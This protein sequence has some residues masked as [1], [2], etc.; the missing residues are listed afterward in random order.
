[1]SERAVACTVTGVHEL[2]VLCAGQ[3]LAVTYSSAGTVAVVALH[4]ASNGTR[5]F[6]LY[7]HLHRVL[8]RA[9]I[10]VATFDR[11]GEGESTGDPSRGQFGLQVADVLAVAEALDV[12]LWGYS[13]GGWVGP[14]AAAARPDRV[15]FLV[16]IASTGVTPAEQMM[17]ATA[18]QLRR[19]GHDPRIVERALALRHDFD[20]WAHGR[21]P[22][23]GA[24]VERELLATADEPWRPLAFLPLGLLDQQD[25]RRWLEEMD[26]DPTERSHRATSENS[27][28]G[29]PQINRTA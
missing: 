17:Y 3:R 8:P 13:Q 28:I 10:G 23:G 25:R 4:G 11:R 6:F 29:S 7:E 24:A 15:A 1:M 2:S 18:Q 14:L 26:F 5:D 21:A 12:G 16:L 9:G 20:Q 27:S 19:A 22:D